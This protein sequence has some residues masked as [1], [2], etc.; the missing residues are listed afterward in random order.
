M[1]GALGLQLAAIEDQRRTNRDQRG[2][3]ERQVRATLPLI[4]AAR[5]LVR[6]TRERLPE[7]RRAAR[8]ADALTREATPLV[9]DLRAARL[10]DST[11]A[12]GALARALLATDLGGTASAIRELAASGTQ[13]LEEVRERDLVDRSARAAAVIPRQLEVQRRTLAMQ[14]RTLA[15]QERTLTIQEQALVAIRETLAVAREAERH[16]ESLDRKTGGSAP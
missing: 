10:D 14:E 15:I 3:I 1:L 6:E 11:R 13:L 9:A 12:V 16:A 5:P 7:A 4:D 8:R 2:L